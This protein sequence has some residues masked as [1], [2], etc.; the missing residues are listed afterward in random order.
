MTKIRSERI[1]DVMELSFQN[2]IIPRVSSTDEDT[3]SV[4][5]LVEELQNTMPN[6]AFS[7]INDTHHTELRNLLEL[8]NKNTK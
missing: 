3:L 6:A 7:K 5:D 1:A 4:Q 8:F 2:V